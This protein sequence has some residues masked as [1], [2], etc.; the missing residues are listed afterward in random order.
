[1]NK[2][3]PRAALSLAQTLISQNLHAATKREQRATLS[4]TKHSKT[5]FG[6]TLNRA[7]QAPSKEAN[8]KKE[9]DNEIIS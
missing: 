9:Q 7:R 5:S 2:T 3:R 4:Q 8:E 1:M 6:G